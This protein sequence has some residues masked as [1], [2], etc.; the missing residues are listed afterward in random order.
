MTTYFERSNF[1]GLVFTLLI[2]VSSIQ[3]YFIWRSFWIYTGL[4]FSNERGQFDEG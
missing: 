4:G 1:T 3:I 2:F